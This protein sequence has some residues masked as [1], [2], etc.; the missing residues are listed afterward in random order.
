MKP[1]FLVIFT[2]FFSQVI[3]AQNYT[4]NADS[5]KVEVA[6]WAQKL[7]SETLLQVSN[8]FSASIDDGKFGVTA[9]ASIAQQLNKMTKIGV[10]TNPNFENYYTILNNLPKE[11]VAEWLDVAQ[12]VI[13]KAERSRTKEIATF[14]EF[15]NQFINEDILKS[16]AQ[17]TWKVEELKAYKFFLENEIP[18]ISFEK[19]NLKGYN[20][21]DSIFIQETKGTFQIFEEMWLGEGGKSDWK[22][23]NWQDGNTVSKTAYVSLEQYK[24]NLKTPGFSAPA[25]LYL[26]NILKSPEKGSFTDQISAPISGNFEYPRFET[27]AKKLEINNINKGINFIGGLGLYGSKIQIR[28]D[29][30]TQATMLIK[31]DKA[32]RVLR[33]K[34]RMYGVTNND[35]I[36]SQDAEISLFFENDSI[37]HPSLNIDFD[38]NTKQLRLVRGEKASSKIA[39][40][41]FY[42]KMEL[43]TDALEWNLNED[44]I[45]FRTTT[46]KDLVPVTASSFNY[47]DK[48]IVEK[49][50]IDLQKDPFVILSNWVESTGS[51]NISADDFASQIGNFKADAVKLVI[52]DLVKDGFI[53]YDSVT[54]M[55]QIREKSRFYN[56]AYKGETDYDNISI[57]SVAA[58]E[59]FK[60]DLKTKDL[61]LEGVEQLPISNQNK[62]ALFPSDRNL[63]LNR[64]RT[65]K[66]VGD[67]VASNADFI[68]GNFKFNYESFTVNL[69]SVDKLLFYFPF[70]ADKPPSPIKTYISNVGGVLMVDELDNKSGLVKNKDFPK[71][72]VRDPS[73]VF[74]DS[75]KICNGA[76]GRESFFFEI[77]PFF[78][79]NLNAMRPSELTLDGEMNYGKIF[80]NIKQTISLQ[81]D[82]TLG[83]DKFPAQKNT[84]A[85]DNLAT[86]NGEI[87]LKEQ[88]LI[89]NGELT[90]L[91]T[92][93]KGDQLLY[94]LKEMKGVADTLIMK[95]ATVAGVQ[96]PSLY[97]GKPTIKWLP[98]ADSMRIVK[99][100]NINCF[101]DKMKIDGELLLT[102]KGLS[103]EGRLFNDFMLIEASNIQYLSKEAKSD[104]AKVLL[105]DPTNGERLINI[106]TTSVVFNAFENKASLKPASGQFVKLDKHSYLAST[107]KLEWN[108]TDR[109]LK[110]LNTKNKGVLNS[111]VP[112]EDSLLINFDEALFNIDNNEIAIDGVEKVDI[113]DAIILPN[114]GKMK[115]TPSKRIDSLYNATIEVNKTHTISN[116]KLQIISSTSFEGEGDYVYEGAG[117]AKQTIHLDIIKTREDVEVGEKGK[118][119]RNGFYTVSNANILPEQNFRLDPLMQYKGVV[120]LD[121]REQYLNYE[122]FGKINL[123]SN[124][125]TDWFAFQ[126]EINPKNVS[127]DLT[128]P[129][130]EYKDSLQIG[131]SYSAADFDLYP[132]FLSSKTSKKDF[133]IFDARGKLSYNA[134]DKMYLVGDTGRINYSNATGNLLILNDAEQT[135]EGN[136]KLN[137]AS[138]LGMVNADLAGTFKHSIKDSVTT[139]DD[140]ILGLNFKI[141]EDIYEKI[142]KSLA[143]WASEAKEINF[144]KS[145]FKKAI[146]HLFTEEKAAA[147]LDDYEGKEY[148]ERPDENFDY[149]LFLANVDMVWDTL[150]RSFR[151]I[152]DFGLSYIGSKPINSISNGYIEFVPRS[153]GDQINIYIELPDPDTGGRAWM[154]FSY[155]KG[156]MEI[157]SSKP[158]INQAIENVKSSKASFS[159][160]KSGL[161][162]QFTLGSMNKRNNFVVRM[163]ESEPFYKED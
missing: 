13:D 2:I 150:N 56:R 116:A 80:P 159:D 37:Y 23:G 35:K 62:V 73:Y 154:F 102:S 25:T 130:G 15:T 100:G 153:S 58:R 54:E 47:F 90:F 160:K 105:K 134:E 137:F 97:A 4:D 38:L 89:P 144:M 36:V 72:I 133:A 141:E 79:R 85:Y 163:R 33:A 87:T 60:I 26:D 32:Q 5:L 27:D 84:P 44:K 101:D 156:I 17:R 61:L 9:I 122:G 1:L 125:N 50:R 152:G 107:E 40:M 52:F 129:I 114:A 109:T 63:T 127:V 53:Y 34:S 93:I 149:T 131:L 99:N 16:T 70:E 49:Y 76:Y 112:V 86:F 78:V 69:D 145:N 98:F 139:F 28:G 148:F 3:F 24:I 135:I 124:I 96:F 77:E 31:N 142:Q 45:S 157:N 14:F 126:S 74:F 75:D 136:G 162:Y 57:T 42:H 71:L 51:Y 118:R 68:G 123:Q 110:F 10:R 65:I 146:P 6:A 67:L 19:V 132:T 155:K 143:D 138:D 91:S 18:Q 151:S 106:D 94:L 21:K 30:L 81:E 147:L 103:S 92:T 59:N 115:L 7:N 12:F 8:D 113:A 82:L 119:I 95:E 48:T 64:D 120:S 83:F 161:S 104:T 128:N 55:I 20:R 11:K 117:L 46:Q 29:S 22:R 140:L 39:F 111:Q 88:G 41:D 108:G 43:S 66:A 158:E 121:S